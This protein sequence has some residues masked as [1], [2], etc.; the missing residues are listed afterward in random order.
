MSTIT[1]VMYSSKST[2][3]SFVLEYEYSK[4]THT[5][6]QVY[7]YDYSISDADV[8]HLGQTKNL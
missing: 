2:I 1:L 8:A 7:E 5:R 3:T 6:V 4:T